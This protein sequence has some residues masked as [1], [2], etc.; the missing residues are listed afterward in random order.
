MN[1]P[2]P[3]EPEPPISDPPAEPEPAPTT[4]MDVAEH[5]EKAH[6]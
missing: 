6:S 5:A 1:D 3:E 4:E 2:E